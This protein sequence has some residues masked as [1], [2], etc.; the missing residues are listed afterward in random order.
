MNVRT[1]EIISKYISSKSGA[2]I[3]FDQQDDGACTDMK[4]GVIHMPNK[5]G[6][7]NVLAILALLMHESAHVRYSKQALDKCVDKGD[8]TA[9][10]IFNC[11][12]DLRIDQ[13]NFSLLPNV[14]SFYQRLIMDH[15][16]YSKNEDEDI[17]FQMKVL[18]TAMMNYQGFDQYGFLMEEAAQEFIDDNSFIDVLSQGVYE[19]NHEQWINARKTIQRIKDLLKMA[20]NQ[21]NKKQQKGQGQG[22][23][24]G[25]PQQGPQK[26]QGQGLSGIDK[27]LKP[28]SIFD[29]QGTQLQGASNS[30]VGEVALEEQTVNQ[31]KELLNIKE[32]KVVEDGS[33]L[34]TD[35]LVAFLTGEVEALFKDDAYIKCKKSKILFL[36]DG[37]GSMSDPLL[38]GKPRST[39]VQKCVERIIRI[40]KEVQETEGINV[41]WDIAKFES[42]GCQMLDKNSW[43]S[44]YYAGGGTN[45]SRA[46]NEALDIMEKD[47]T[48]D[49]K[50]MIIVLTDGEVSISQIDSMKQDIIHHNTNVKALVIGVGT[51][52]AGQMAIQILG[53]NLILA[54]ENA[55]AVILETIKE[56]L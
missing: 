56:L 43:Q 5:V 11:L 34:D 50:K 13:K 24:Q 3:V 38:D 22:Q 25:N 55:N 39:V 23:G 32:R 26:G 33:V 52:P 6:E 44:S 1:F 42:A 31:F 49:G 28:N 37:S 45:L 46:F 35:N 18:I 8:D 7:K 30:Q 41:D 9:M 2:Q 27:M 16:D 53:D 14:K 54:E 51:N 17:E 40:L 29:D 20:Q 19:L 15:C 12:E 47:F 48:S 36:L 21:Q 10:H 4:T